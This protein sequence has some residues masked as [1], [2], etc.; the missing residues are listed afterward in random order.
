M[1]VAPKRQPLAKA[2]GLSFGK[3]AH[4]IPMKVTPAAHPNIKSITRT[5]RL[6]VFEFFKFLEHPIWVLLF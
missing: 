2:R 6:G 1:M 4:D 3:S 5:P